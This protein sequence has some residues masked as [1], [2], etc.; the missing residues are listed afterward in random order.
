MDF[1]KIFETQAELDLHINDKH[2]VQENEDRIT[3]KILSL[4]VELGECANEW[5]RFKF[6][7]TDQE[8]RDY[9]MQCRYSN[10]PHECKNPMLEEY[11][12][13]LHFIVSIGLELKVDPDNLFIPIFAEENG[14][15]SFISVM[16]EVANIDLLRAKT[17]YEF[18]FSRFM[19]LG[20]I[21]GLT[22]EEIEKAYY[23]KN[24][25]NH[26]RQDNNY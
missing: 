4:L 14:I 1:R 23:S 7:S 16:H 26:V 3:K 11:V 13:C 6:W 8:P 2:P 21:L 20:C 24:K 5:R 19:E 25:I 18:T 12:D 9:C 17:Q 15:D 10:S 22:T